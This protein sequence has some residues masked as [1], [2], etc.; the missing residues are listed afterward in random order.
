MDHRLVED[1]VCELSLPEPVWRGCQPDD[2]HVRPSCPQRRQQCP[3]LAFRIVVDQ[4]RLV[5]DAQVD[6]RQQLGMARDRLDGGEGDLRHLLVPH[7]RR[8][9]PYR[10][11]RPDRAKLAQVLL[12]QFLLCGQHQDLRVVPLAHRLLADVGK[13]HALPRSGRGDDER[14]AR[15]VV[16]PVPQL[17]HRLLLVVP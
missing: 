2:S 5:E 11:E 16:E 17:V 13:Q 8:I 3:C 1:A 7:A 4:V 6:G 12:E 10:G 15:V 9:D 14:V